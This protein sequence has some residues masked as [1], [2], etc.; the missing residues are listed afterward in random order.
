MS[1]KLFETDEDLP[2]IDHIISTDGIEKTPLF[3]WHK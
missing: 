2:D 3:R 1:R